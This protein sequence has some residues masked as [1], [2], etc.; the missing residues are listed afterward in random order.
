MG[1]SVQEMAD[2]T[3][4][5]ALISNWRSPDSKDSNFQNA[6][7]FFCRLYSNVLHLLRPRC[8]NWKSPLCSCRQQE[9]GKNIL[10]YSKNMGV[11]G[12]G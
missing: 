8:A 9:T 12:G 2:M 5:V 11:G 10:K 7:M 6:V 3:V 1:Q 4:P